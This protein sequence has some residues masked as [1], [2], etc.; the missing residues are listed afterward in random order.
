[1]TTSPDSVIIRQGEEQIIPDRI[2]PT[3]GFSS[4]VIDITLGVTNRSTIQNAN[5]SM[6]PGFNS[7]ELDVGIERNQSSLIKVTVFQQTSKGIY[8]V[9]SVVTIR[10]PSIA[11]ATKPT[12][13]APRSGRRILILN[14][15]KNTQLG[16]HLTKPINFTVTVI[17]P[18][19]IDDQFKDFWD[20]YGASP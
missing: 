5:R 11:T 13:I 9:P 16:S 1:M 2:Q 15:R 6:L 3:S 19:S 17:S 7:S 20:T 18:K 8:T 4:D 14:Y 12:Y 10:E